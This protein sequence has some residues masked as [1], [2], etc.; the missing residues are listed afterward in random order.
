MYVMVLLTNSVVVLCIGLALF[1]RCVPVSFPFIADVTISSAAIDILEV[2][3][4]SLLHLIVEVSVQRIDSS[5]DMIGYGWRYE[6][7]GSRGVISSGLV[8]H[9]KHRVCRG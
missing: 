7:F 2:F 5:C 3:R 4:L 8:E 1:Q 6:T 9:R